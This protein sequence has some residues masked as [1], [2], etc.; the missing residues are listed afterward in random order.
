MSWAYAIPNSSSPESVWLWKEGLGWLWSS[1][2]SYP[3]LYSDTSKFWI[4]LNSE[5]IEQSKYYDYFDE[6]WRDWENFP[7]RTIAEIEGRSIERMLQSDKSSEKIAD[8][9]MSIIMRGL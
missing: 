3:Y 6:Q 1:E 7:T 4:Y 9:I 2:N 5:D 8:E